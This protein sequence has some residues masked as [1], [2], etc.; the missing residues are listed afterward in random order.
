MYLS[1]KFPLAV[2]LAVGLVYGHLQVRDC[3]S[4]FGRHDDWGA[5]GGRP[6]GG[7]GRKDV[8]MSHVHV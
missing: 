3:C 1:E 7:K 5:G 4:V 2:G 6:E 8:H